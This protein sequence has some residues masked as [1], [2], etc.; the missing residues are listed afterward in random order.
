MFGE[1]SVFN[2]AIGDTGHYLYDGGVMPKSELRRLER[3]AAGGGVGYRKKPATLKRSTR[4][5]KKSRLS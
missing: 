5:A 1:P 3:I 4:K 2:L